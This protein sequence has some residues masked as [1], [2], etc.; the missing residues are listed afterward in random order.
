[1]L[2]LR[3]ISVTQFKNYQHQHFDFAERIV[4]IC[5]RNGIGKTNLLDAIYYCCFTK[6]YFTRSDSQNV[7]KG[8]SGFRVEGQFTRQEQPLKVV[9]I[10]R[11]NGRKEFA[12]NEDPYEK[13]AHHIGKLPCVIIA[14]DDVQII[15]GGSEERRRFLDAL[16]CQ[17]N[18]DYL[19]Q[20]MD[21]NKVM[22]QRNS[23]LKAA[24]DRRA[25]DTRLLDVYDEQLAVFTDLLFPVRQQFL[26]KLIPL[27]QQFYSQIAGA[28]EGLSM[29]YESQLLQAPIRT[30]LTRSREKDMV[31]QRTNTGIHK[32][33]IAILL[34]GQPFKAI[35]SQ[36][37]RKSLLFAMKLAEF[38]MLK[39]ANGFAPLLLLDDV[40]EKLDEERMHNLLQRVCVENDGPVFI[41]DT[42]E[43]R[44]RKHLETLQLPCQVICL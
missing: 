10:L 2:F 18:P 12:V 25:V 33:D 29:A 5:G 9:S 40:F 21:Y 44:L 28:E 37:Q 31:L 39:Q 32:D 19:Q 1:M 15:T 41:T 4:G 34:N 43:V 35:A 24:A 17:L 22:Q 14:P 6:S 8:A 26:E 27:T 36:G 23:L 38:E 16:L 20:L 3:S 7:L 42:H 30:L 13:L 11:E